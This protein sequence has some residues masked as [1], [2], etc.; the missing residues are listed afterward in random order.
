MDGYGVHMHILL[1]IVCAFQ[2]FYASVIV[3]II[4]LALVVTITNDEFGL[5]QHLQP[6]I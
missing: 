6:Q 5:L 4:I 2:I 3:S 1:S